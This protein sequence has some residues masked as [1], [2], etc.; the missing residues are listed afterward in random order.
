MLS[1]YLFLISLYHFNADI[2]S[3]P[4]SYYDSGNPMVQISFSDEGITYVTGVNTFLPYSVVNIKNYDLI[5]G[6]FKNNKTLY[7]DKPVYASQ[8]ETNIKIKFHPIENFN[9]YV[10]H[11]AKNFHN[12]GI[13]LAYHYQDESFS[14]IHQLYKAKVIL[15]LQFAFHN[16]NEETPPDNRHVY[17]G[18]VPHNA[19]LSLPYKGI[20]KTRG[21]LPTWGFTLEKIIYQREEYNVDLPCIISNRIKGLII[22]DDVYGIFVKRVFNKE[23]KEGVCSNKTDKYNANYLKCEQAIFEHNKKITLKFKGIKVDFETKDLFS[24]QNYHSLISSNDINQP[25]HNFTGVILGFNFINKF[26]YTV[27][28]YET[29]QIAFYTDIISISQNSKNYTEIYLFITNC[30]LSLFS[31]ILLIINKLQFNN[32]T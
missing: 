15:H 27:F 23:I 10:S 26:N 12:L 9:C 14:F 6:R 8:Y 25:V 7:L 13:S 20:E 31:T 24:K 19:H 4:V 11:Q 30:I 16:I 22:S 21:D 2:L 17:I 1:Y 3:L 29:N 28:D 18:G 32:L 5:K